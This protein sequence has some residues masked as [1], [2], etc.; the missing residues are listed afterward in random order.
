[1][2]KSLR[3]VVFNGWPVVS[4]FLQREI[5]STEIRISLSMISNNKL[6][7]F[8]LL[9][10][11]KQKSSTSTEWLFYMHKKMRDA[12]RCGENILNILIVCRG[13]RFASVIFGYLFTVLWAHLGG[14]IMERKKYLEE[15]EC[16]NWF[17]T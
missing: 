4:I 1:M 12:D 8:W 10:I 13:I 11:I 9:G 2:H 17:F 5:N 6:L 7:K 14:V 16:A 15:A 3:L